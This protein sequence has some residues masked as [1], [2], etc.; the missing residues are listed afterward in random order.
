VREIKCP[1]QV[2]LSPRPEKI[3]RSTLREQN[4]RNVESVIKNNSQI[5]KKVTQTAEVVDSAIQ[6]SDIKIN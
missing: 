4:E 3:L 1:P 2:K 6:C 5:V